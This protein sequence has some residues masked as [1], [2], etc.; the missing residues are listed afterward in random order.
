MEANVQV[1]QPAGA[2][3]SGDGF[4][5]GHD[6]ARPRTDTQMRSRRWECRYHPRPAL[7][8]AD[9]VACWKQPEVYSLQMASGY[10]KKKIKG[11]PDLMQLASCVH[12]A[13]VQPSPCAAATHKLAMTAMLFSLST[14]IRSDDK[15]WMAAAAGR[16]TNRSCSRSSKWAR[17]Y[18]FVVMGFK[19]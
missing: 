7:Q 15:S 19:V 12:V 14:L 5:G 9:S 13:C 18:G 8:L 2:H 4:G 1:A 17:G 10:T 11:K 16:W 6:K 3:V